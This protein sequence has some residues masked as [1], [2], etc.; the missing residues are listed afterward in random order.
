MSPLPAPSPQVPEIEAPAAVVPAL[1]P[2]QLLCGALLAACGWQLISGQLETPAYLT[3]SLL[4]LLGLA[5]AAWARRPAAV[6]SGFSVPSGLSVPTGRQRLADRGGLVLA[7]ALAQLLALTPL[8]SLLAR[9]R[10]VPGLASTL[11]GALRLLGLNAVAE[12]GLVVVHSGG[13]VFEL[14]PS[15]SRLAALPL[16]LALAAGVGVALLVPLRRPGRFLARWAAALLGAAFLRL[17]L[18]TAAWVDLP[19]QGLVTSPWWTLLTLLPAA[20]LLPAR[21]RFQP[22]SPTEP[23]FPRGRR[24]A[25][26]VLGIAWVLALG[27]VPVGDRLGGPDGNVRVLFDDSH[28]TWE[29]TDTPFDTETYGQLISYSYSSFYRLLEQHYEVNRWQ[30]APLT[31]AAL[32]DTD[33]LILKTPT[34][35]FAASEIEAVEAFVR[36]GGGLFLIGDHTNLFGMTTYL[37]PVAQRFGLSFAT[38]DTFAQVSEAQSQWRAPRWLPHPIASVVGAFEFET[39]CTLRV[40]LRARIPM[41]GY[42]LG[43]EAADY[44]RPGFFGNLHLDPPDDFG[45]FAQHATLAHGAGRV[46]AFSDSTPLSN[47][48]LYFPGRREVAVATV[49]YLARRPAWTSRHLPT[50]ATLLL[51]AA[52][53]TLGLIDR[54]RA[55]L[56]TASF[57]ALG[58]ATGTVVLALAGPTLD[59]PPYRD[60]VTPPRQVVFDTELSDIYLPHVLTLASDDDLVALDSLLVAAQR[61]DYLPR[62][63]ED[64]SAALSQGDDRLGGRDMLVLAHPTRTPTPSQSAQL[65]AF[66]RGGGGLLILDGLL[67]RGTATE[68]LLAVFGLGVEVRLERVEVNLLEHSE[69]AESEAAESEDAPAEDAAA[70]DAPSEDADVAQDETSFVVSRPVLAVHGGHTLLADGN[71]IPVYSEIRFG[72]GVVGVF[73]DSLT[74]SKRELG[75]RF[76]GDPTDRQR[77][78]LDLAYWLLHR[79]AEGPLLPVP[80]TGAPDPAGESSE[81]PVVHPDGVIAPELQVPGDPSG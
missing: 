2:R 77:Q 39:S 36:G 10:E 37:N 74:L 46:A 66:V 22:T 17:L 78:N 56:A 64:L 8:V 23:A 9:W 63:G 15:L 61:L 27:W 51:L 13:T 65:Q 12:Q 6:P 26:A 33:V 14:L 76:T 40:P 11:A 59:L 31:A 60:G 47:F 79:I 49:E 67:S 41:L 73:T 54:G 52:V 43:A 1:A 42:G 7:I 21:C 75:S 19:D 48:S 81:E 55:T 28:G 58:L 18:I 16:L 4:V 45:F 3:G 68:Q 53:A 50:L 34:E 72:S 44:S 62:V 20:C 35:P 80:S 71:G 5:L 38:D 25:A 69:A 32:A 24:A 57:L 29:P 70:E 30:Q